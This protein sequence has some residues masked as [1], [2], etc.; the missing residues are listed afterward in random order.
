MKT[1]LGDFRLFSAIETDARLSAFEANELWLPALD[2]GAD[3]ESDGCLE[4]L[5]ASAACIRE[6]ASSSSLS[7]GGLCLPNLLKRFIFGMF[8]TFAKQ[9][10][11]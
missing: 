6:T 10:A 5:P 1:C 11:I 8:H 4:F 7:F 3:S 2:N 9:S